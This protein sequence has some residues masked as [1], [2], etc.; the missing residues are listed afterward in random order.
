MNN[1][2]IF[3]SNIHLLHTI[4]FG[5]ETVVDWLYF[6]AQHSLLGDTVSPV[7]I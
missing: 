5:I 4:D 3:L 7:C 6:D 2:S 1:Q